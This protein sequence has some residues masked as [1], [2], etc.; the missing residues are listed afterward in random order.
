M[1]D[2][3]GDADTNASLSGALAGIKY[4]YD[5]LPEEKVNILRHD[6]L[7]DLSDRIT[8]YVERK[9]IG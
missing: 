6:Y 9:N 1:I 5:A 4:G 3:G 2:L 8:E 7:I